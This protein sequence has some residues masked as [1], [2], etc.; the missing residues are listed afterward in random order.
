[1]DK[2]TKQEYETLVKLVANA[3]EIACNLRDELDQERRPVEAETVNQ[4][5]KEYYSIMMKLTC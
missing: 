3:Y 1:M 5:S 2:L 4:Q